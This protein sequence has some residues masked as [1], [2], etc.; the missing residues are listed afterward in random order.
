[1]SLPFR[2]IL[3]TGGAGF[4]GSNI[5][6]CLKSKFPDC[7]ITCLDNLRRRGSELNLARLRLA[8]IPF[9]HGDIRCPEDLEI[10][11]VDLV[12]EC[13]AEPSVLAG[14]QAPLYT[15]QT[16]LGGAVNCLEFCRRRG[17]AFFFISTSRV[18]PID[19][20]LRIG[21]E[22]EA[23]R[24]VPSPRQPLPGISS[25]GITEQFPLDGH[26]SLYGASKYS[27]ELLAAEYRAAFNVP[28]VV[29]RCGILTGPWQMAKA[30]QGLI[31]LW[32][33]R[34]YFR[35][36]LE[37]IGHG[38]SGKQVRDFLDI[39]DYCDLLCLQLESFS[40]YDGMTFNV[41]GGPERSVSLLELTELARSATGNTVDI[42]SV[43]E[44]RPGDIPYYVTD[45][46]KIRALSGWTPSRSPQD[47]FRKIAKWIQDNEEHLRQLL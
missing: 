29:N 10:P 33:I 18:Y 1:M 31:A 4:V 40:H 15:I 20:L 12:L 28:Y 11:G 42:R 6:I 26:R 25:L 41:G 47:T 2:D 16:N 8:G 13:S 5:A 44:T 14:Y 9:V 46:A 17:A 24:F 36:P 7:R 34:H 23:T 30:D 35:R 38:G 21:L 19:Q 45:I 43:A 27:V 39:D 32:L 3:I 37:Y 22:E